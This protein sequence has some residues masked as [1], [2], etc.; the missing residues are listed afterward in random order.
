MK[1]IIIPINKI[2]EHAIAPERIGVNYYKFF[3]CYNND[4]IP[5]K[6]CR[7][8]SGFYLPNIYFN[9]IPSN[10]YKAYDC[11]PINN[12]LYNSNVFIEAFCYKKQEK[13]EH[14]C[15]IYKNMPKNTCIFYIKL[16]S[17]S[18]EENYILNIAN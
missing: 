7:I 2:H 17:F 6:M 5:D 15:L 13:Q 4:I 1:D 10:I 12:I 3:S 18:N 8:E 9:V 11:V 16:L 14:F